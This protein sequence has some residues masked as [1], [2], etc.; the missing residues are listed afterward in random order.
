LGAIYAHLVSL[1]H[2]QKLIQRTLRNAPPEVVAG[3]A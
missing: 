1:L 2:W 3:N